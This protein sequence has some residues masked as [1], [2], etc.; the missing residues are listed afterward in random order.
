MPVIDQAKEALPFSGQGFMSL[1]LDWT[2][3]RTDF[4]LCETRFAKL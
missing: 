4:S 3:T 1:G 2:R